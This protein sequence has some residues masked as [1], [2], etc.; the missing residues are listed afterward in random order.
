MSFNLDS[1]Q[2]GVQ[3]RPPRIILLGVPKIGKSTFAAQSNNAVVLPVRGEEGIDELDIAKIPV[4]QSYMDTLQWLKALH[5]DPHDYQTAV[6]DS[7]STLQSLVW[8]ATCAANNNVDCIEKVG[9]GYGKGYTE[10]LK[11]WQQLTQW[12]DALRS[13]RNMA[14]IIVGH[15]TVKRHD[16]PISGSYSR[17]QFDIHE[18][19]ANLLFRWAD[20][21]LFCNTKTVV[22]AEDVGFNKDVKTARDI[23]EGQRFLYTQGRPSHPGGGRGVYGRLP[24]ELPL[25]WT[26]FCNAVAASM[27]Q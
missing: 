1:I 12:L 26:A 24:Y 11:Y 13:D 3:H 15:V 21:I 25:D 18:S 2:R 4:C 27:Q 17:Y 8:E 10:A 16:D 6:V 14:S 7:A 23:T 20:A 19:A 5:D 22:V 9:G